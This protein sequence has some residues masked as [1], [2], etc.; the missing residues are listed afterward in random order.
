MKVNRQQHIRNEIQ[1]V[2]A[3]LQDA[4]ITAAIQDRKVIKVDFTG[5]DLRLRMEGGRSWI[6]SAV[7]DDNGKPVIEFAYT[8]V[9]KT[10][11]DY[12]I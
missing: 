3:S 4:M 8:P 10:I 9:P 5:S 11:E 12:S 2:T 1:K 6:F 7:L